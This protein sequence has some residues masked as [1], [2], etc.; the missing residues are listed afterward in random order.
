[1]KRNDKFE[2]RSC[3]SY[4]GIKILITVF[5]IIIFI[6]YGYHVLCLTRLQD[7]QNAFLLHLQFTIL[8]FIYR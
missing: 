6:T 2:I 7:A 5:C 3:S 8:R 4:D 1:M